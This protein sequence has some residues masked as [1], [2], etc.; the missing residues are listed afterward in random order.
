[1]VETVT[2]SRL[3]TGVPG[4]DEILLGGFPAY[5]SYLVQGTAGSG[6]TTLGLH[7]LLEGSRLGE[8]GFYINLS[9]TKAELV[10]VALSHDWSLDGITLLDMET[11]SQ[12]IRREEQYTVFPADEVELGEAT[13]RIFEE[14]DR[15][16]P[17]RVV[18]DS[19]SEV[20]LMA[21]DNLR[22]RRQVLALKQFMTT[23][24]CTVLLLD[25]QSKHD[26]DLELHSISHGVV[27]MRRVERAYGFPRR[28]LRV[29]KLRASA[30]L[31]GQH[32]YTIRKGGIQVF[33]RLRTTDNRPPAHLP[34]ALRSGVP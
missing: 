9:E 23:R 5:R 27:E 22:Y 7:F 24:N 25:D 15:V 14:W 29:V 10:G 8:R 17:Q 4:L 11:R 2:E 31:E 21:R 28:Q 13:E 3:S 30:F 20:R 18:I 32:D 19:L 26:P 33:P 34:E 6:K 16:K 12:N 1:M